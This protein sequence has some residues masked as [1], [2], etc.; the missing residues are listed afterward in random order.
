MMQLKGDTSNQVSGLLQE[1]GGARKQ[2]DLQHSFKH[3]KSESDSRIGPSQE[4][5]PTVPDHIM[6]SKKD[7]ATDNGGFLSESRIDVFAN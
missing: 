2:I 6:T 5:L 7:D 3:L 1:T 4:N